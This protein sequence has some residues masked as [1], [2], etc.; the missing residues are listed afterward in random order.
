MTMGTPTISARAMARWVASRST[1]YWARRSMILWRRF[2]QAFGAIPRGNGWRPHSQHGQES[3]PP[4]FF[5]HI[6]DA[7]HFVEDKLLQPYTRQDRAEPDTV[8]LDELRRLAQ[9]LDPLDLFKV[10]DVAKDQVVIQQDSEADDLLVLVSGAL[11]VEYLRPDGSKI[12]VANILPGAVVG[13]IAF[14]AGEK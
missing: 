6:D 8:I 14:Y 2:A 5:E 3:S 9:P 1:E 11:R 4:L 10:L 13:E 12:P 7:L